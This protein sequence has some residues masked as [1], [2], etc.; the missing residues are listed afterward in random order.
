MGRKLRV[1][2]VFGTR[3][4][5]IKFAPVVHA[6][7]QSPEVFDSKVVLTG[8]HKEMCEP[9]IDFFGLQPDSNMEIMEPNQSLDTIVAKILDRLPPLLKWHEPSVV[10]VQGDTSSAFAAALSAFHAGIPVGH[11]EAGLR[12]DHPT[13][14]FPEEMNRRLISRIASFHFAPTEAAAENLRAEGVAEEHLYLSGNTVIDALLSSIRS[15]YVFSSE[16][17]RQVDFNG[18]KVITVT[19][20]RRES[21][22]PPLESILKAL[23]RIVEED[24]S[25][26][27]VFP[28]HYNPNVR[29]AV[30]R[31]TGVPTLQ[32][33]NSFDCIKH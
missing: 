8:Q 26:E 9:Y 20:H 14:P 15:D 30:S 3:P 5:V 1:L 21:F 29:E 11:I 2:S 32:A 19:I 4:D 23:L 16:L 31:L 13:N 10:L 18:R 25:V 22:G 17:L 12:T 28:V 33:K 7:E 24:P 27:V 6:M